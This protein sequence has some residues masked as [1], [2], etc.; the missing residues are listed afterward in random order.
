MKTGKARKPRRYS[1][2]AILTVLTEVLLVQ[3]INEAHGLVESLTGE[4][5]DGGRKLA[6]QQILCQ[7]PDLSKVETTGLDGKNWIE[8]LK[9][10]EKI[11]GKTLIVNPVGYLTLGEL[12]VRVYQIAGGNSLG[13]PN[14]TL[15]RR[16]QIEGPD[17]W[18]IM[19]NGMVLNKGGKWIEELMPSSRSDSHIRS[20]R[21]SSP[22]KALEFWNS[23]DYKRQLES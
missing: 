23:G 1:L 16:R 4:G 6:K 14:V 13:G 15:E 7:Y 19:D 3:D 21:F 2:G 10:C 12:P 22:G 11:H 5:W 17:K 18:V 8:W 20:T 9:S